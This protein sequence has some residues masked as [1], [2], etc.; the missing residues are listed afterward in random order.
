MQMRN[1]AKSVPSTLLSPLTSAGKQAA[2]T[3]LSPLYG[4]QIITVPGTV[5]QNKEIFGNVLIRAA[6]VTIKRSR[7]WG[8]SATPTVSGGIVNCG[9]SACLNAMIEDSTIRPQRFNY[10][11]DGVQGHDYTVRRSDISGT[12]DGFELSEQVNFITHHMR[13]HDPHPG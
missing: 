10:L 7:I 5:I 2:G 13:H 3:V 6:N 4:D 12:V 11:L 1:C 8:T 9:S